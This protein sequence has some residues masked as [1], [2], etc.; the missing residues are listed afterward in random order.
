MVN[1]EPQWNIPSSKVPKQSWHQMTSHNSFLVDLRIFLDPSR[2]FAGISIFQIN[3]FLAALDHAAINSANSSLLII[4][5]NCILQIILS[6]RFFDPCTVT[7][8]SPKNCQKI[9]TL[10][11]LSPSAFFPPSKKKTHL[12]KVLLQLRFL[13]TSWPVRNI[14]MSPPR[15]FEQHPPFW[16]RPINGYPPGN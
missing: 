11:F 6:F 3:S 9:A 16:K 1:R 2:S 12:V 5:S 14:Q 15:L 13:P 8:N 10:F 7:E 4:I